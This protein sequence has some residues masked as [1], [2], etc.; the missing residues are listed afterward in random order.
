MNVRVR[1]QFQIGQNQDIINNLEQRCNQFVEKS[2]IRRFFSKVRASMK[3]LEQD[4]QTLKRKDTVTHEELRTSIQELYQSLT[5]EEDTAAAVSI[6]NY[7]C[8]ACGRPKANVIGM[9]TDRNVAETLG[10]PRQATVINSPTSPIR[11]NMIFGENKTAYFGVGNFGKTRIVPQK[12][13]KGKL[14]ILEKS[15]KKVN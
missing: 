7:R 9:I 11:Q 3:A 15:R 6:T 4:V 14:P 12:A 13:N 5:K 1:I 2:V 8:L 10:E